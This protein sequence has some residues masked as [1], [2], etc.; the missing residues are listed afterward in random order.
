MENNAA[1]SAPRTP[2]AP[3]TDSLDRN[4]MTYGV[5]LIFSLLF[6][7]ALGL[8][9][10]GGLWYTVRR[11]RRTQQPTL[12]LVGSFVARSTI[13]LAGFYGIVSLLGPR[14]EMLALGLLGF[15][16]GRVVLVRHWRPALSP[17][18]S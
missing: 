16:A 11:A 7:G 10:F 13:A 4:D 9:Y 1:H 15:M 6:G 17:S 18:R 3:A 14:W 12:L 2:A 8:A 5:T